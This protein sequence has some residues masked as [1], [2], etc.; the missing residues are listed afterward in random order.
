MQENFVYQKLELSLVLPSQTPVDFVARCKKH[1]VATTGRH[2]QGNQDLFHSPH[3]Q[4]AKTKRWT[5]YSNCPFLFFSFSLFFN[6][7]EGSYLSSMYYK[8]WKEEK[9]QNKT[10]FTVLSTPQV[11]VI[12]RRKNGKMK[13]LYSHRKKKINDLSFERNIPNQGWIKNIYIIIEK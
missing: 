1:T 5:M 10:F 9:R 3:C 2:F 13:R 11:I 4:M 12:K 7:I 8:D 6:Q